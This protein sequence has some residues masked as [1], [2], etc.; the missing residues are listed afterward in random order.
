M[1]FLEA[2]VPDEW[3]GMQVNF[4]KTFSST[5]RYE[6]AFPEGNGEPSLLPL[7]NLEMW[8]LPTSKPTRDPANDEFVYLR[9][10][11]GIMHYDTVT[12]AT[13]A[14]LMADYLKS[15]IT[16]KGLPPDLEMQARTSRF[17]KQFGSASPGALARPAELPGTNLEGA[18]EP[19][20]SG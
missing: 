9:F 15:I 12:G 11:R 13:Q 7:L 2:R 14:L 6:D 20:P 18:F 10:Q 16:G 5:V 4:L 19:E 1:A 17:Y 3:E 8:G